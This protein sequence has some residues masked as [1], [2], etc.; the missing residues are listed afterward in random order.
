MLTPVYSNCL[1]LLSQ[2][3]SNVTNVLKI[4]NYLARRE[5][6][7][8]LGEKQPETLMPTAALQNNLGSLSVDRPPFRC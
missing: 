7:M 5:H 3:P 4:S 6:F 1:L 2:L 8:K